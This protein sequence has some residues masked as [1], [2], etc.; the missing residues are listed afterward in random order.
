MTRITATQPF[1][2][3]NTGDTW[4]APTA[5]ANHLIDTGLATHANQPETQPAP[6]PTPEL[7]K[8]T[9][10]ATPATPAGNA[11]R[12]EWAKYAQ[13]QG[14]TPDDTNELTRDEIRAILTKD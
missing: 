10:T 5:S 4:D 11:S 2:N 9:P 3:R 12:D 13:T 14:L 6:K 8:T 1:A 7:N